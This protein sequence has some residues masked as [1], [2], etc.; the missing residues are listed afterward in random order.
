MMSE[1]RRDPYEVTARGIEPFVV[2]ARSSTAAKYQ[3]YRLLRDR[4]HFRETLGHQLAFADFEA[5]T[6]RLTGSTPSGRMQLL[7]LMM[8]RD[9]ALKARCVAGMTRV[10]RDPTYRAIQSAVMKEMMSRPEMR[11]QARQHAVRINKNAAIRK[12]QWKGRRR[13]AQQGAKDAER[14]SQNQ[15]VEQHG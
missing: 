3:A 15:H 8:K 10:R 12:R 4:G 1:P 13:K 5:S 6:R 7:N 2:Y 11:E 9:P 14:S